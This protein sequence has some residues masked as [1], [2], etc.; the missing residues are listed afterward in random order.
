MGPMKRLATAVVCLL[1]LLALAAC[2]GGA[3]DPAGA[4][5]VVPD[6]EP[7]IRAEGGL[8]RI[9]FYRSQVPLMVALSPEVVV[10]GREVGKADYDAV[11]YRD[12][13]PGRYEVFLTSDPDNPIYFTLGAGELRFVK[14][15]MK[16]G[17]SGTVLGVELVEE[18][19]ARREI[20]EQ[21]RVRAQPRPPPR[22]PG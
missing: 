5:S 18:P 17:W 22:R 13:L 4:G 3:S 16:L 20:A 2:A 1:A 7:L 11:F 8:G 14:A 9:Y 15:V 12:G 6:G 21:R 10:N 19:V